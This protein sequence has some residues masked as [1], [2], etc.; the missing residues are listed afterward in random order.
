MRK[1]LI[2]GVIPSF[3]WVAG[4]QTRDAYTGEEKVASSTTGSIIGG[5]AGAVLGNQV[6][7]SKRARQNARLGGAAL[8]AL[9]GGAIGQDLDAQET[10][11][12]RQLNATGVGVVRDGNRIVL[13]MPGAITFPTGQSS[14]R[15]NFVPV[16]ES[17]AEVLRKYRK[18]SVVIAGHTDSVGQPDT[19]QVLSEQRARSVAQVLRRQGVSGKRL[20]AIGFGESQPVATNGTLDGRAKN[21]R[22]EITLA[23]VSH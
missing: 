23:P 16:L 9:V 7:G 1:L 18:T 20:E 11:L 4:C 12:R 8:G 17:V 21:R 6:K 19:N 5:L 2:F 10:E 3:I 14:I 15:S 22:V 13:N